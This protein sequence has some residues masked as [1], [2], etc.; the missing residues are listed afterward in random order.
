MQEPQAAPGA[1][2]GPRRLPSY[3][4]LTVHFYLGLGAPRRVVQEAG[5]RLR[6]ARGESP[7][8]VR[9]AVTQY[10]E[11]AVAARINF[12]CA[13]AFV[14]GVKRA[15]FVK[16]FPRLRWVHGLESRLRCSRVDRSWRAAHLLPRLGLPTPQVI[17]SAQVR[18]AEGESIEYL[19]TEWREGLVPFPELLQQRPVF[20]RELLEEFARYLRRCHGSGVYLRDLVKNVLIA[21]AEGSRSFL[22]TD[23]DGLHPAR[24]PNRNRVRF[25]FRQ[26]AHWAGPFSEAEARAIC[27][28][29]LGGRSGGLE[30]ALLES[31]L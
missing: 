13:R 29:Y 25:H 30:Q 16:E 17:G 3:L 31:L 28:A 26:L 8:L 24:W 19:V 14:P 20:R 7:E 1:A 21:E 9:A 10:R 18:L 11:G 6:A 2:L 15:V 4:W 27:A 23:L 5:Y 12:R 22:L